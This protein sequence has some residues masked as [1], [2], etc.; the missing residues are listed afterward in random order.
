MGGGATLWNG[1]AFDCPTNEIILRN[2]RFSTGGISDDCNNGA[3]TGQ[4]VRVDN[5]CYTSQL[6]VAV[7]ASLNNKTVRCTLNSNDGTAITVGE[8][9][10]T[11]ISGWT[12]MCVVH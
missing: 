6:N 3:I 7:S 9:S 8:A 11:V 10:L 5:N 12:L 4:S 1:T 2:S